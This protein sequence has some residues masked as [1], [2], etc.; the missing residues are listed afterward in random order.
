MV[1]LF[2]IP[3]I[4]TAPNIFLPIRGTITPLSK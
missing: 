1:Q 2:P 4:M 3:E